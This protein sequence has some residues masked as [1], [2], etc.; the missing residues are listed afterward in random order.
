MF[1]QFLK[2]MFFLYF[3]EWNFLVPRLRK[4]LTFQEGIFPARKNKISYIS[5]KKFIPHFWMTADQA[6]KE[7]NLFYS[8]MDADHTRKIKNSYLAIELLILSVGRTFQI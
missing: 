6:V 3:R 7:K 4:I 5:L 2:K 1:L 8:G